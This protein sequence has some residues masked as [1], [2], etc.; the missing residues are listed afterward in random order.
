MQ[1]LSGAKEE[2]SDDNSTSINKQQNNEGEEAKG[3]WVLCFLGFVLWWV[4]L[5]YVFVKP[6]KFFITKNLII[7]YKLNIVVV[8]PQREKLCHNLGFSW[9]LS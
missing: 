3:R 6:R 9:F 7:T 8:L 5:F 2:D 1:P 4:L